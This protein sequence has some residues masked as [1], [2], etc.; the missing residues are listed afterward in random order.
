MNQPL[1]HRRIRTSNLKGWTSNTLNELS[2]LFVKQ[3]ALS[4][5]TALDIGAAHGIATIALCEGYGLSR[6]PALQ[7]PAEKAIALIVSSQGAKGGWRYAPAPGDSDTSVTGWQ[8][9]ALHSARMAGLDVPE[10]V[11]EK[12]RKW[13]DIAGGGKHGGGQKTPHGVGRIRSDRPLAIGQ[14]RPGKACRGGLPGFQT[15]NVPNQ[16][17]LGFVL[18]GGNLRP[19]PLL[20]RTTNPDSISTAATFSGEPPWPASWP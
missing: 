20:C 15:A 3:C 18:S 7:A 19:T 17:R 9:M 16:T 11:F 14:N 2:E 4:P 13:L 10:A 5:Q 1:H 8:Y 6:D 12:A